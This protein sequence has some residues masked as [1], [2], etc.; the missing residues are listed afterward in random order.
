MKK[1][2][3]K[4]SDEWCTPQWLFDELNEEFNFTHD[5]CANDYNNK[6]G[7]IAYNYLSTNFQY[8]FPLPH[9]AFMN[10]PYSNPKPFIEKAWEDSKLFP[11]VCLVKCDPSTRWWSVFW[12]YGIRDAAGD[13]VYAGPKLGCEVRFFQKRIKFDPPVGVTSN[14][15]ASFPSAL[16]IMDR[17]RVA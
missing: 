1:H 8:T 10:P 7:H 16:V 11:I 15:V 2:L 13:L 14:N 3:V 12:D 6:M 4:L 5:L 17:R 9:C